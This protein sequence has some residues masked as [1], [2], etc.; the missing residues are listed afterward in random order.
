MVPEGWRQQPTDKNT[1][2]GQVLLGLNYIPLY[3]VYVDAET[4]AEGRH[5]LSPLVSVGGMWGEHVFAIANFHFY[6]LEGQQ[7][8]WDPDVTYQLGWMEWRPWRLS[9]HWANYSGTHW[10]FNP[11]PGSGGLLKGAL[12]V[13]FTMGFE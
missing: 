2:R 7:Q 3:D 8:P 9:I 6:P 12:T 5:Q 11:I 1:L 13:A 10:W 4:F